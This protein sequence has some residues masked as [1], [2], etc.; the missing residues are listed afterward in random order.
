MRRAFPVRSR[1]GLGFHRRRFGGGGSGVKISLNR[2]GFWLDELRSEGSGFKFEGSWLRLDLRWFRS[3][4]SW[5][6]SRLRWFKSEGSELRLAEKKFKSEGR[7]VKSEPS[8]FKAGEQMLQS[9]GCVL[10]RGSLGRGMTNTKLSTSSVKSKKCELF[11]SES[12]GSRAISVYITT[13]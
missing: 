1:G 13:P 10:G 12:V 7:T 5:L 2:V 8:K 9:E 6:K 3:G 11:R 4:G